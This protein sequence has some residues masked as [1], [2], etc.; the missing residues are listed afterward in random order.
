MLVFSEKKNI[1]I[2]IY[3]EHRWIHKNTKRY[4]K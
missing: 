2:Y 1:Y 4:E 3:I